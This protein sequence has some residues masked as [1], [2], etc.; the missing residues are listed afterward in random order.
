M[1]GTEKMERMLWDL[2]VIAGKV[3][4]FIASDFT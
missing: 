3:Y 1:C 4:D 2:I